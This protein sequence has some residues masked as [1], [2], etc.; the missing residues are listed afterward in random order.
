MSVLTRFLDAAAM[1]ALLSPVF[2]AEWL[3]D[4]EAAKA[5]AAA[6][7]KAVL[8]DF[9]GSDWCGWCIHLRRE[10]LD[11]PEFEAYAKDKF[12]FL[13]VDI[14]RN[15]PGFAP[16]L[17]RLNQEICRQYGVN[18]F[19]NVLVLTPTGQLAG[20]FTGGRTSVGE[21]MALLDA[22]LANVLALRD[23]ESLLGEEK[24]WASAGFACG[25]PARP[26]PDCAKS[27]RGWIRRTSQAFMT[28]CGRARRWQSCR[29]TSLKPL[30]KGRI[31]V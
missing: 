31:Q 22:A 17:L 29:A 15:T 24:L 4:L 19:P 27:W 23:A 28:S 2:G 8:V 9:T 10:V 7:G 12:V 21:V 25:C 18:S 30:G 6:E 5:K 16:E 11:T 13:E 20:G 26:V 14:P 3:C 1:L